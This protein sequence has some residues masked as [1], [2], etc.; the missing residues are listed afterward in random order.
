MGSKEDIAAV[1]GICALIAFLCFLI[2]EAAFNYPIAAQNA[3]EIC[4]E[5]G[6]DYAEDWSRIPLT[7]TPLGIKCNYV[8]YERK[9]IDIERAED[10]AMAI[11]IG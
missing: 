4:I 1:I 10:E 5:R 3:L 2:I 7:Q 6:Y 11:V 9:Q 8:G